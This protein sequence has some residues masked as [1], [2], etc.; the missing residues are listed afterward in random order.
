MNLTKTLVVHINYIFQAPN[1]LEPLPVNPGARI[2]QVV[3][4]RLRTSHSGGGRGG[5]RP[6]STTN[7][8][9]NRRTKNQ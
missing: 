2:H 3:S 6:N 7:T 1:S 9:N 4:E 8:S 5:S